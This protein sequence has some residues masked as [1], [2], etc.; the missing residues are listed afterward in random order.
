MVRDRHLAA[1]RRLQSVHAPR[2]GPLPGFTTGP[3]STIAPAPAHTPE[4]AHDGHCYYDSCRVPLGPG[5]SGHPQARA[6]AARISGRARTMY[7]GD[8]ARLPTGCTPGGATLPGAGLRTP[9]GPAASS[10]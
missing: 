8:P 4:S 9:P 3:P 1:I 2:A 6:A 5:A 7:G 10:P